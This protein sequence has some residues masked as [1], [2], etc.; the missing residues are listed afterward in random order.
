[1]WSLLWR[2]KYD[3]W[4]RELME[5]IYQEQ[6]PELETYFELRKSVGWNVLG[7]E[8]SEKAINS[9]A[10][11][12]LVKD[13]E[14]PVAMGRAVGDGMYYLIVDVVVRPEYQMKGIGASI[15]SKLVERIEN[16]APEGARVSIQLLSEKGKE[17][18]YVKQ[19]FKILPNEW[20]GPAL[21]RVIHK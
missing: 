2:R 5:L 11:F 7:S 6:V 20:C 12:V 14:K 3:T 4:E 13:G 9:S 18:F 17:E 8:Q 1:M 21:R 10:F 16:N 19:G 15:V